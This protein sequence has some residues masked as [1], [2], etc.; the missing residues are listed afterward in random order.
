MKLYVKSSEEHQ[1][2]ETSGAAM[3]RKKREAEARG[4]EGS[5]LLA[6]D[7]DWELWTPKNYYGSVYL[8]RLYSDKQALWDT[9]ASYTDEWFNQ[10]SK[11]GPLY[12]IVNKATGEKYQAQLESKMFFDANDRNAGGIEGLEDFCQDKPNID[13]YLFG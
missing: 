13:A 6:T 8:G 2:S 7:G 1:R 5:E 11:R 9:C 4:R 12:V 10:Y 3:R